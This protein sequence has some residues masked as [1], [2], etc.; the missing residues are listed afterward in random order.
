MI[1]ESGFACKAELL[2]KLAALGAR[3]E[4]VPVDLDASRRIGESQDARGRDDARLLAPDDA[5]EA[6]P[7]VERR[8]SNPSGRNCRW[9]DPGHD[10]G[11]P[12]REAGVDVELFERSTDLGGLVGAFDF[13]GHR[14]DRFYHVVL[15]TDDRVIGLATS[16]GSASASASG[17]P[18]SASTTTGDSSR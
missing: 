8:V 9:R 7:G 6:R 2:A 1:T 5:H 3:V 13:D 10:G 17:R 16:S 12:A 4:E 15:P 14:V 18:G 11:I